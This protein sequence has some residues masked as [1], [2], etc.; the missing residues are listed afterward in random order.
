MVYGFPFWS[1]P[2]F[3]GLQRPPI[4]A[5]YSKIRKSVTE[6][7]LKACYCSAISYRP[8][9]PRKARTAAVIPATPAPNTATLVFLHCPPPEGIAVGVEIG[10]VQTVVV[11]RVRTLLME[12]F[13]SIESRLS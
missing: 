5:L 4:S 7:L 12:M 11:K 13:S 9:Y 8:K 6:W 2:N 10:V 3:A 1:C